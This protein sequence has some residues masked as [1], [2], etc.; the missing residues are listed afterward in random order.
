MGDDDLA[1]EEPAS[2]GRR[3]HD[4]AA[5]LVAM[6]EV[7]IGPSRAAAGMWI[8][9]VLATIGT[10]AEAMTLAALDAEGPCRARRVGQMLGLTS[11]G[12]TRL[13]DG[14]ESQGLVVRRAGAGG[15]GRAVTVSITPAGERRLD[16]LADALRPRLDALLDVMRSTLVDLDTDR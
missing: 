2:A 14:L 12:A 13:L 7:G 15:D 1:T 10:P 6:R 4:T 8:S 9:E 16:E 11:G 5:L 3:R